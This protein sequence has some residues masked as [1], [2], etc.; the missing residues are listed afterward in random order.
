LRP[1]TDGTCAAWSPA[2]VANRYQ[3]R[4]RR[5]LKNFSRNRPETTNLNHQY[6]I[7]RVVMVP[8]PCAPNV[9]HRIMDSAGSRNLDCDMVSHWPGASAGETDGRVRVRLFRHAEQRL[10]ERSSFFAVISSRWPPRDI[11]YGSQAALIGEGLTA[12]LPAAAPRL[13]IGSHPSSPETRSRDRG[14]AVRQLS[15]IP[16]DCDLYRD[17]RG[18]TLAAT[19]PTPATD[20][21]GEYQSR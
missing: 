16:C 10:R 1:S 15:L 20:I 2:L 8:Y 14:V 3:R 11:Q 7:R 5:K 21:S 9:A 17:L 12:R 4:A 18:D 13:A 19:R 6:A